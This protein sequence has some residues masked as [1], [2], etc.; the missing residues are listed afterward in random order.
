MRPPV[1]SNK[2][3][4]YDL[5]CLQTALKRAQGNI[6]RNRENN[7]RIIELLSELIL[8]YTQETLAAT[9]KFNKRYSRKIA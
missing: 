4:A 2:N 6:T 9:I 5:E 8:I 1:Q 7:S 3:V